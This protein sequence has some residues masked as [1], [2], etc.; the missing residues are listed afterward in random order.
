MSGEAKPSVKSMTDE[1]RS[2][3]DACYPQG[4]SAIQNQECHQAFFAG[5]LCAMTA[6]VVASK[7]PEGQDVKASAAL[8]TEVQEFNRHQAARMR[9]RN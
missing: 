7:L 4:M 1:W 6:M 9:A 5:A 3:R 2:Y 8:W